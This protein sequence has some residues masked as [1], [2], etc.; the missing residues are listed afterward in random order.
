MAKQIPPKYFYKLLQ[1]EQERFAVEKMNESYTEGDA[2]K[3][4]AQQ[5]RKR[6]IIEPDERPDEQ[7]LKHE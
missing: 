3:K 7:D 4:I 2:W 6:Q 5:A 1:A